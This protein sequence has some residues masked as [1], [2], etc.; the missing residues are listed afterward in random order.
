MTKFRDDSNQQRDD[1]LAWFRSTPGLIF[2]G[3]VIAGFTGWM[4]VQFIIDVI[5]QGAVG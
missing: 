4:V 2:S 3:I 5:S 1:I